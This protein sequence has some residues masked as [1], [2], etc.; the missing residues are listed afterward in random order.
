[1]AGLNHEITVAKLRELLGQLRDTDVLAP[2]QVYNLR[3][4]RDGDYF[5]Y[6]DLFTDTVELDADPEDDE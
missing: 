1:M 4:D 5:G 6:I 3:V 2:N